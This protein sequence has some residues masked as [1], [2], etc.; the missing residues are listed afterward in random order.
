[1]ELVEGGT[2]GLALLPYL[3][4]AA[5]AILVDAVR[6]DSAPGSFVRLEGTEVGPA[7]EQRLSPHQVGVADLLEGARWVDRYPNRVVLLGLVPGTLELGVGLS[8]PVQA[9][10][11]MLMERIVEEIRG[12]GFD[13]VRRTAHAAWPVGDCCDV[14]DLL[15]LHRIERRFAHGLS[16]DSGP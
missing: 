12:F 7:V 13:L 9:S 14:A 15:G 3:E 10:L 2:L 4:D 8:P 6:A 5:A 16:H 1:V 11:P